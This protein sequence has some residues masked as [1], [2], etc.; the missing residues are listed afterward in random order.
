MSQNVIT[1][2]PDPSTLSISNQQ[3]TNLSSNSTTNNRIVL[4][5]RNQRVRI[6][7]DALMELP[8]S[9]LLCLFPN[10]VVLNQRSS[11]NNINQS[12]Q[13]NPDG[14]HTSRKRRSKRKNQSDQVD[15]DDEPDE[16]HDED[17]RD[18]EDDNDDEIYFVD[19]D[20][21]CLN[22]ILNYF[23]NA[24]LSY[25]GTSL[26]PQDSPPIQSKPNL[27]LFY[28]QAIIVL[29][30]E[31]EYFAI[32][33]KEPVQGLAEGDKELFLNRLKRACGSQLLEKRSVFTAL[34]RNVSREKNVAEQHLIDMLC[35][36]GFNR[37][38]DWGYRSL[39]PK[40]C[41]VTSLALVSLKTG[42]TH[43]QP[44]P[45]SLGTDPLS[46]AQS[47]DSPEIDAAQL[48]TAQKLLLFWRKPARKCWW[49][50]TEV[51]VNITKDE[52]CEVK[53][54]ARRVWTLELSLVSKIKEQTFFYRSICFLSSQ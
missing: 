1:S 53:L 33:T 13:N 22:Y 43:P 28:R 47:N 16:D 26:R 6:D 24:R 8:E 17:E 3:S 50:S 7:R 29:R 21:Q 18:D 48:K 19:F 12:Q 38:D 52:I 54:W 46:A 5:L 25:Y 14:G 32:P 15:N 36:S 11:N 2:V 20:S 10:G 42:I 9:I 44:R 27:P 51:S 31:L 35:M 37:E 41:C 34:Q 40:R 45:S 39:E 23:H 49:D 30:E 4:E